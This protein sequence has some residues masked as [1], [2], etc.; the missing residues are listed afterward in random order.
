MAK[1]QVNVDINVNAKTEGSMAQLR[2][3]KK[4]LKETA[5]G[6]AEFKSLYNQIDDLEDK[7]KSS[8]NASSD[9]ID[10]L[11]GAG[12]PLGMLGAGLNKVKVAT[13]SWG[14][15]LKATGIGLIVSLIGGLVAAFS[16]TEGSMKKLEPLMIAMEQIFGGIMEAMQPVIDAFIE[17]AIQVMPYVTKAFKVVY[18]AVTAV[19]QSLGKIGSAIVKLFKGDFSGAWEDAKSSVTGF[20]DNYDGASER[21]DAGAKK[22]TKTQK[23]NLKEQK[24]DAD[25]AL[26]DQ[27]ARLEAESKLRE[28]NLAKEKA[29]ALDSA[30]TEQDKLKIEKE[31][32]Q[33]VYDEKK[34]LLDKER[35]LYPKNSKDYKD[36]TAQLTALEAE[37]I[38]KKT[39]FRDKDKELTSKALQDD[40]KAVQDANKAKIDD[41]TNTYNIQ[42]EKYGENSKEARTAQ[43]NIFKAQV[44]GLENQKKLLQGKQD[45]TKEEVKQ[46]ADIEQAQKN[47]TGTI[48]LENA[49]RAKSDLD[50]FLKTQE[51]QKKAADIAFQ[52][53]MKRAGQDYELQQK[54]LDDKIAQ[55]KAYYEKLLLQEGLTAEQIKKIK[56]DQTANT[57]ANAEAQIT[58][59]AA[60]TDAQLKLLNAL[61][62]GINAIADIVGKN[63]TAGKALAVAASLINTYAAIAGQLRAA[64]ASPG[65]AIPGYAIAQAV[66]TG[67]VGFKAVQD[68]IKTPVPNSAGAT[69]SVS[70]ST[71]QPRRL[72][73]GGMV[74]GSGSSTSDSIPA[75]LSNGESVINAAS[76]SMFAP[77]LSTINEIGGGARFAEG[78]M[79]APY[80]SIDSSQPFASFQSEQPM[81]K[82]YV[83]A[84]DMTS[85]QMLDRNTK[86]RSTL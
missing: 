50:T 51:E 46:L 4:Q 40:L 32:A 80:S 42:K 34:D 84:S 11:E 68:I 13:Q 57:K 73:R 64:T 1:N 39:E 8:K 58:I 6:S 53:K 10:S 41:L 23:A 9:W 71:E 45:L 61:G 2:E 29:I 59:E 67:L 70:T 79:I 3:L 5:A 22:M 85:Q 74:M 19:F 27:K 76:T 44:E 62:A 54:I 28:A 82:T 37:Y 75:M 21:F 49:K 17:L 56:D 30:K 25:K 60:K 16:Q 24:G 65:A 72:A 78:G 35:A 48:E 12:G 47:L 86:N 83:V 31:F 38:G 18:S 33:K 26:Q 52:D 7:L 36:Y 55:D 15:A 66:A 14:A 81:I 69:K 77:L 20:M 43:D 63:T